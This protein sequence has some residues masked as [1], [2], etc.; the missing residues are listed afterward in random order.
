MSEERARRQLAQQNPNQAAYQ[1]TGNDIA[2]G[3]YYVKDAT[4]TIDADDMR[5]F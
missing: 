5:F 3:F 4:M 1:L 2:N